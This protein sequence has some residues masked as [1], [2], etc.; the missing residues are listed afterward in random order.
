MRYAITSH[1]ADSDALCDCI[2]KNLAQGNEA[3]LHQTPVRSNGLH[4]VE[5]FI[6][7][8]RFTGTL[9]EQRV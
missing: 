5:S 9:G 1:Y 4:G 2:E 8:E 3:K 7:Q 6:R